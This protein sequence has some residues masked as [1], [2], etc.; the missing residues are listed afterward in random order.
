MN[1]NSINRLIEKET[2]LKKSEK[3]TDCVRDS[4]NGNIA[5]R[6]VKKQRYRNGDFHVSKDYQN[7]FD[8]YLD[9]VD[10]RKRKDDVIIALENAG[11]TNIID[12]SQRGFI[13]FD[14]PV[15]EKIMNGYER[16]ADSLNKLIK[17]SR[18]FDD[19]ESQILFDN[20]VGGQDEMFFDWYSE[21]YG[22]L[23]WDNLK[24]IPKERIAE[25]V[26]EN[27]DVLEDMEYEISISKDDYAAGNTLDKNVNDFLKSSREIER[28]FERN[29]LYS[30]TRY[31]YDPNIIDEDTKTVT[32][33]DY[34]DTNDMNKRLN[35]FRKDVENAGYRLNIR[36]SK[37]IKSS[38]TIDDKFEE[39]VGSDLFAERYGYDD[40]RVDKLSEMGFT[41]EQIEFEWDSPKVQRALKK[42]DKAYDEGVNEYGDAPQ[43]YLEWAAKVLENDTL[44][45]EEYERWRNTQ[46]D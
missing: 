17:S 31:V 4:G 46:S 42:I 39:Y 14:V 16:N 41:P 23:P 2:G 25:Y 36:N 3:Y 28:S 6:L 32:F 40:Y 11:C 27:P 22:E 45:R 38:I 5:Y 10:A 37:S 15:G 43:D 7:T 18:T 19:V 13:K 1:T 33:E 9:N 35:R 12:N 8:I 30:E 34:G 21:K 26:N 29:F 20:I 44:L 24:S